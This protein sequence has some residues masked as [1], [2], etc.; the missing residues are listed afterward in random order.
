[1]SERLRPSRGVDEAAWNDDRLWVQAAV[2]MVEDG[3]TMAQVGRELEVPYTRL[4]EALHP[5]QCDSH[6]KDREQSERKSRCV[7]CLRRLSYHTQVP[8]PVCRGCEQAWARRNDVAIVELWYAGL[9][10]P[11]IA[12]RLGDMTPNDVNRRVG[13]IRRHQGIDLPYRR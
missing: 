4:Y 12:E 11:A 9:K 10:S 6:T 1:M 13:N 3:F 7:R 5:S 8:E 2:L